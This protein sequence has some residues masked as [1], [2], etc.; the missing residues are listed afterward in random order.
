MTKGSG[1]E[2]GTVVFDL[3]GAGDPGVVVHRASLLRELLAPLPK[4][5][6]QASK[7]LTTIRYVGDEVELS[8]QDGSVELFDAVIGADGIFGQVRKHVVGDDKEY[9]ASP[10]GFWD[11][12]I[13]VP[14][15]KARDR[16]GSAFFEVD[17]Q[18]G[19]IG[20]N[21]FIMH[22]VLENRTMV[23]VVVSA[24]EKDHPADRKRALTRE[25]LTE[26][27]SNW[28][29]GPVG[30]NVIDAGFPIS[31]FSGWS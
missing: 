10:A 24:V 15:E 1:P 11:C 21:A 31:T 28:L 17:R 7:R 18:Y 12:R 20:D 29:E 26:T 14:F 19:W 3:A 2:A 25:L 16:I 30:R 23:Q 8:F 5:I 4:E 27:L 22:D 9:E 13:L 6:L